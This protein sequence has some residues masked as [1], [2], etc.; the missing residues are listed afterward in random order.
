MLPD[1]ASRISAMRTRL[2]AKTGGIGRVADRQIG[3]RQNLVP[4]NVSHRHFGGGDQEEIRIIQMK[5]I[6]FKLRELSRPRHGVPVYHKGWQNFNIIVVVSVQVEHEVYQCPFQACTGPPQQGK[7][8]SGKLYG[9]LEIEHAELLANLP[10][11]LG[12][13][14]ELTGFTPG[15]QLAI[16]VF[17]GAK[18]TIFVRQI[19]QSQQQPLQL[20]LDA[21]EFLVELLDAFGDFLHAG[22]FALHLAL[23]LGLADQS[24]NLVALGFEGLP[25]TEQSPATGVQF[26]KGSQIDLVSTAGKTFAGLLR[27]IAQIFGIKHS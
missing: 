20:G 1:Q 15:T 11:G 5:E 18:G 7:T 13:E 21:L 6:V 25:F 22:D 8:G 16:I 23:I 24:R 26:N 19:G 17:A 4:V 10:V 12:L 14:L 3:Y 2:F 27:I 9:P